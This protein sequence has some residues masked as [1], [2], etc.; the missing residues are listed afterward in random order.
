MDNSTSMSNFVLS[1]FVSYLTDIQQ[2]LT[3]SMLS[4]LIL[5]NIGN[6]LNCFVFLQRSLR[7]NPCSHYLF[8]SSITNSIALSFTIPTGI[9]EMKQI[10]LT[11]YSLIY[12]KLRLYIYHSLLM[13]SRYLI[14]LA[15]FDRACLSSRRPTIRNLSHVRFARILSLFTIIFWFIGAVHLPLVVKIQFG[16]CTLPGVYPLIFSIYA[17]IFAGIIPPVAM[18]IFSAFT[19]RNLHSIHVRIHSTS[20]PTNSI[21][22]QR[23]LHLIRMLTAQ[24]IIYVL[25]TTPYPLNTLYAAITL[26]TPKSSDRQAI[27]GFIYFVTS[28]FLLFIN[29]SATFYIYFTTSKAFR[30]EL[31]AACKRLWL[32]V[33]RKPQN[34]SSV[35]NISSK[36]QPQAI[37][38]QT[39]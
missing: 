29:P 8:V 30:T 5:G 17:V 9:Y 1:P 33:L 22:R 2:A 20:A 7:S 38:R 13:I 26:S 6:L 25:T 28:T 27:E 10:S 35:R 36:V 18:T 21:M 16:Y 39:R 4:F 14:I 34:Q 11:S 32:T 19:L 37:P 31:Q 15:C 12:C 23:D 24:V 3:W